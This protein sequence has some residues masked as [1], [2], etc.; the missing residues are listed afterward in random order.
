MYR[1]I[2]LA[3]ASCALATRHHRSRPGGRAAARPSSQQAGRPLRALDRDPQAPGPL[4]RAADAARKLDTAPAR[5]PARRRRRLRRASCAAAS[6]RSRA[7]PQGARDAEPFGLAAGVSQSTLDAIAACESGGDPT[8][9]NAAG[10]YG[11]YQFDLG[12][13]ASVGGSGNPAEASEAEQDYRASLLYSRAGSVPLARLR[14]LTCKF[15]TQGPDA[16]ADTG[17]HEAKRAIP[18]PSLILSLIAIVLACA[19]GA[20]AAS[21]ING[22]EI[23]KGTVTSKQVKNKTLKEGDL[24]PSTVAALRGAPIDAYGASATA[25]LA[26]GPSTEVLSLELPAGSYVLGGQTVL[27]NPDNLIT[28]PVCR[29]AAAG[30]SIRARATLAEFDRDTLPFNLTASSNEPFTAT[31]TCEQAG[32]ESAEDRSLTATRVDAVH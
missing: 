9:V 12:T 25:P 23:K 29:L 31:L 8:A 18:A 24:K 28:E 19:G 5:R 17:G 16:G 7:R 1:R 6:R 20:V 13:W 4:R 21:K 11:K 10:Y 32:N 14:R 3:A 2:K 27:L 26:L 15:A 30:S 22:G